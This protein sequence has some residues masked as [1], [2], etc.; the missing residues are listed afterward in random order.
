MDQTWAYSLLMEK[1]LGNVRIPVMVIF[2]NLR[3]YNGDGNELGMHL[4]KKVWYKDLPIKSAFHCSFFV[5]ELIDRG[6][7]TKNDNTHFAVAYDFTMG[8]VFSNFI[9]Q[10]FFDLHERFP[11][12]LKYIINST[13]GLMN[14][15]YQVINEDFLTSSVEVVNCSI[16]ECYDICLIE[17][18]MSICFGKIKKRLDSDLCLNY[19]AV[20]DC[21]ILGLID[22]MDHH[23]NTTG[24]FLGCSTD[25]TFRE[26]DEIQKDFLIRS[27]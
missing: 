21:S 3:K 15:K 24:K 7:I 22:Q 19:I 2:D 1:C 17:G 10:A 16:I 13:T 4:T 9:R 27:I 18:I 20:I 26:F 25:A 8:N 23:Q 11:E 12:E 6:V 14:K 5:E